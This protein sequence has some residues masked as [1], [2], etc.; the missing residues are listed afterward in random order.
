M[1]ANMRGASLIDAQLDNAELTNANMQDAAKL[2]GAQL[3]GANLTGVHGLTP[4]QL[5]TATLGDT[6]QLSPDL[7]L[8]IHRDLDAGA[9]Q[10]EKS[11]P[12]LG[13]KDVYA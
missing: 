11:A 7:T 9:C 5:A 6:T 10:T 4:A 2:D 8:S 13:N 3:Q 1:Q 12:G